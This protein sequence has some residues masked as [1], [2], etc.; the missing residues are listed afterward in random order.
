ML[1]R[2]DSIFFSD[3]GTSIKTYAKI[4]DTFYTTPETH[5]SESIGMQIKFASDAVGHELGFL[6]TYKTTGTLYFKY[7][8]LSIKT[9]FSVMGKIF[10]N[11]TKFSPGGHFP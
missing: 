9:E 4:L 6:L 3:D 8:P 2:F 7:N 11:Y 5:K 10:A 1:A